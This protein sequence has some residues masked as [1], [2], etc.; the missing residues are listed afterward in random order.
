[1]QTAA[2]V[3]GN[4]VLVEDMLSAAGKPFLNGIDAGKDE[5]KWRCTSRLSNMFVRSCLAE[6][7]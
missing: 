2:A 1:M 3:V 4:Q 7:D 6:G 5:D